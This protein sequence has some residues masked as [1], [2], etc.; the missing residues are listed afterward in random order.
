MAF[1]AGGRRY[2]L[3]KDRVT[4]VVTQ[5]G[6]QFKS[7]TVVLT[8]GT[9][10][11]LSAYRLKN[12]AAGRAGDPPSLSLAHR[13]RDIGLPVGRLKTGTP[14]ELTAVQLITL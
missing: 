6:I 12:Y 4:G 1:S 11:R 7:K 9:F 3:D 13:L 10:G 2:S 8:A 5:I 14:L